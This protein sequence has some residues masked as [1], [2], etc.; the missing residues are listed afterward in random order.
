[1][2]STSPAASASAAVNE[3]LS[4][5]AFSA[6]AT[7]RPCRVAS[8]RIVAAASCSTFLP[9]VPSIVSPWPPTGWA[10][11]VLVPGAITATSAAISRKN[12]AEAACEPLGATQTTT[13]IG[14]P[15][16]DVKI[17]RVESSAP[18]GVLSSSTKATAPAFSAS[19]IASTT[20][21]SATGWMIESSRARTISGPP[22]GT[23]VASACA[24]GAAGRLGIS[25]AT[26]GSH[27]AIPSRI[28]PR[29][30]RP[31]RPE[32]AQVLVM[33]AFPQAPGV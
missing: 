22:S 2:K 21:C 13:G 33:S 6:S 31:E 15:S 17:R 18:P 24:A 23:A 25:S 9:I 16:I 28:P 1:M 8:E 32:A 11:P 3:R 20:N 10:A 4:S 5:T 29:T 26:T 12:P 30:A 19:A 27:P 14:E 7:S